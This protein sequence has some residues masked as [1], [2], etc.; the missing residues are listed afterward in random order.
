MTKLKLQLAAIIMLCVLIVAI[1]IPAQ[2][3]GK[4]DES[5]INFV[6]V[7]GIAIQGLVFGT[8]AGNG[9]E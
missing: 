2:A 3:F 6:K 5:I 8:M 1:A 9:N 4:L 7:V